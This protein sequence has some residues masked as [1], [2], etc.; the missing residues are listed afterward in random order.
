MLDRLSIKCD[1]D[2]QTTFHVDGYPHWNVLKQTPTLHSVVIHQRRTV[3]KVV[4]KI[5]RAMEIRNGGIKAI[6]F[7][8]C[9]V[10]D[11]YDL[12]DVGAKIADHRMTLFHA[13]F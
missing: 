6:S 5:A 9:C 4:S 10:G 3:R 13:V 11:L 12:W 1:I 7:R 2:K 8:D